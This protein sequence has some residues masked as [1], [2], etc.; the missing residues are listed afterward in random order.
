MLE[1][2]KSMEKSV[3]EAAPKSSVALKE[4]VSPAGIPFWLVEDYA[5]PVVSVEFACE[6]GAAHDDDGKEGLAEMTAALLDEGAG[7]LE[8]T[9]F[10]EAIDDSAIELGF[11]ADRDHLGGRLRTLARHLDEAERLFA[12]ALNAPRFDQEPIDRV[13]EQ[14]GAKL[15][16]ESK[17][18]GAMAT[19]AWRERV[20]AGHPYAR[21]ADGTLESLQ[22]VGRADVVARAKALITRQRLKIAVVGALRAERA[23]VLVDKAF[24]SLPA[25]GAPPALAPP[26]FHGLGARETLDLDVPQTTIRFG[27][28]SLMRDDPDFIA[29]LVVMHVLG[30]GNLTSRLFREVREKRGLAYSVSAS[31]HASELTSYVYG[32]TTTKNERAYESMGVIEDEIRDLANGGLQRE[33]FEKGK[34]F[35]IGSYPLRFD[36]SNKIANQLVNI[37]REGRAAN[38][39]NER[40]RLIAAVTLEDARRAAA[41]IFG[42][43]AMMVSMVGR[44]VAPA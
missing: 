9:A 43:G 34:T 27:R 37:Q 16:H 33:E 5:V 1:K 42:D 28:P 23:G 12:L 31:T 6:G 21:P 17:D 35:L 24:A 13:R 26:P 10:H 44:P 15:R 29:G 39:L 20:F 18:P 38:W 8:S 30:G 7:D 22:R 19:R 41:R 3:G 25:T 2:T 4:A 32:G 14:M 40:N 36:T 11:H